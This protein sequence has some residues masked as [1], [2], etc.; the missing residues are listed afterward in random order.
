MDP[1]AGLLAMPF[2][3]N[4][5]NQSHIGPSRNRTEPDRR[6]PVSLRPPLASLAENSDPAEGAIETDRR[7]VRAVR[8]LFERRS[9]DAPEPGRSSLLSRA[10]HSSVPSSPPEAGVVNTV[11]P[12]DEDALAEGAEAARSDKQTAAYLSMIRTLAKDDAQAQQVLARLEGS[13]E[14]QKQTDPLSATAEQIN[15]K[16]AAYFEST[17]ELNIHIEGRI[18]SAAATNQESASVTVEGEVEQSDPLVLDLDGDGVELTTARDG[19]TFDITGD[20]AKEQTA[21]VTGGDAFLALDKNNNGFIDSGRELFGDQNGA[22]DG[23]EELSKYD[24]N[25]DNQID[26]RDAVYGSLRLFA[27]ANFDGI[28][29]TSEVKSLRDAGISSIQLNDVE[30]HRNLNGGALLSTASYT[31]TDGS[32]GTVGDVNVN[33][34]A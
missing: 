3:T 19:S 33:Y 12:Q 7:S 10:G 28:S 20:S 4:S 17:F 14:V 30:A 31:R 2:Q 32:H 26:S 13:E 15:Q 34:L 25:N 1:I 16:V 9:A 6:Q 24:D 18:E 27:D 29:Q 8:D 11:S 23:F 22:K 5:A 21:F